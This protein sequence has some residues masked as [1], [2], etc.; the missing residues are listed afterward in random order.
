MYSSLY[1]I[2]GITKE[3]ILNETGS[4]FSAKKLSDKLIE[5]DRENKNPELRKKLS[6]EIEYLISNGLDAYDFYVQNNQ[7]SQ[8]LE[9]NSKMEYKKGNFGV[10]DERKIRKNKYKLHKDKNKKMSKGLKKLIALMIAA[11]MVVAGGFGVNAYINNKQEEDLKNNVCVEYEVQFGDTKNE[12]RDVYGL[13]DISFEY[14]EMSGYQRQVA[15]DNAGVDMIDFIAA[16]DVIIARTTKENADKLVNEK[17]AKIITIEEAIDLLEQSG[18]D[19]FAGEFKKA[20][21]GGS[22]IVFYAPSNEKT[23][24]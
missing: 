2:L 11:G 10:I 8:M 15:A 24:G 23:I 17:G 3:D 16:G 19:S 1:D 13:K 18:L 4:D 20:A 14:Q 7:L 21:E 12:L 22:T 5:F 6:K 9:N